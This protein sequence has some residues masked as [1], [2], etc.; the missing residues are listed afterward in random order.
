MRIHTLIHP[1][2][3]TYIQLTQD[4]SDNQR[5]LKK[6]KKILLPVYKPSVHQTES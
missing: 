6:K 3:Y 1:Y 5:K 2:I 4:T